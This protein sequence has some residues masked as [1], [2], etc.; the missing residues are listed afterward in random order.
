[1]RRRDTL[2]AFLGV[3]FWLPMVKPAKADEEA[4]NAP[5]RENDVFVFAFGDREGEIV[6][7]EDLPTDAPQIFAYPMDPVTRV[8]RNGTR[9]N[10][11]LLIRVDTA[12]L[13]AATR[14]RSVANIVAYSAV[15][16][17]TGCD[18]TDWDA[19]TRRF[20]CPCHDSQF[21]PA[22]GARVVGGP[23]PWQLPSLPLKLA[24]G[25]LAAAGEF[26]GRVGFQQPGTDPFGF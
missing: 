9:L 12:R 5:P 3:G 20:Q 19:E 16:T 1:M 7:P 18:I 2:K 6:A 21:D 23:A 22:D 15:C 13:S 17:H 24:E 8:V 25:V 11:V 10:Q 26:E 4:M 14:S